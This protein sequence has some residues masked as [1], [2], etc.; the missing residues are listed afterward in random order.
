MFFEEKI[1]LIILD[2]DGVIVES[3][4]V[5]DSAFA[6]I[7]NRYPEYASDFFQYHRENISLSRYRKF[8]YLLKLIGQTGNEE[9]KKELLRDFSTSTLK[10]MRSIP[11]VTGAMDFLQTMHQRMPLYLA[12]VTPIEDLEI[13][14]GSLRIRSYF[15]DVYGCPPWT[16]PLAVKDILGKENI[17]PGKTVLVGD[18]Y[19]DQNAAIET[20]IHFIGRNSGLHFNDPQ[21]RFIV[22]NLTGLSAAFID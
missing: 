22:E 10:I 8:D 11:F 2:F 17:S 9:L 3:N 16:K 7:L 4:H 21:P 20:G 19:G 15:K 14:L 1:E 18:S 13:I 5:K 12:S 6:E